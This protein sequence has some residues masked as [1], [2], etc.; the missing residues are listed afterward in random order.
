MTERDESDLP[1]LVEKWTIRP[2]DYSGWWKGPPMYNLIFDTCSAARV[3]IIMKFGFEAR[4]WYEPYP[5][6]FIPK[7]NKLVRLA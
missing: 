7:G 2:I 4:T 5:V 3:G 6:L 1:L